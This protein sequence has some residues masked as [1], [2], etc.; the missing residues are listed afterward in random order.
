[1]LLWAQILM[2]G[3]LLLSVLGAWQ[4]SLLSC[5]TA[6]ALGTGLLWY[7][8]RS[9]QRLTALA[10][11]AAIYAA[12]MADP[13]QVGLDPSADPLWNG[14]LIAVL[15]LVSAAWLVLWIGTR[16]DGGL[17]GLTRLEV[18]VVAAGAGVMALR[19]VDQLL[20]SDV[21][22][23]TATLRAIT[24]VVLACLIWWLTGRLYSPTNQPTEALASRVHQL[25]R[26]FLRLSGLALVAMGLL[27][28]YR[29]VALERG[30][31]QGIQAMA[32]GRPRAAV[33]ALEAVR[34]SNHSL[35]FTPLRDRVS[36]GLV[37]AYVATDQLADV[38]RLITDRERGVARHDWQALWEIAELYRL[39]GLHSQAASSYRD[40]IAP[41]R[42]ISAD[43]RE[44]AL[45]GLYQC[46][47]R[48]G[49]PSTLA[50][51]IRRYKHLPGVLQVAPEDLGILADAAM[52]LG[53]YSYAE[54]YLQRRVEL[55]P[56]ANLSHYKLGLVAMAQ[57]RYEAA[58]QHLTH[59]AAARPQFVDARVQLGLCLEKLGRPD[60]SEGSSV[61]RRPA[62]PGPDIITGRSLPN[63][64]RMM[65]FGGLPETVSPGQVL[66]FE[67]HWTLQGHS[68]TTTWQDS[69]RALLRL[70]RYD[71]QEVG[72][73][74][75]ELVTQIGSQSIPLTRD[76]RGA[77]IGAGW[78][79]RHR[80]KIREHPRRSAAGS[81]KRGARR[82]KTDAPSISGAYALECWIVGESRRLAGETRLYVARR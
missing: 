29:V 73:K 5:L 11:A 67:T 77:A 18:V 74:H 27:G 25:R 78:S 81:R 80:L 34:A 56:E 39:A 44:A 46:L 13:G 50:A 35:Q 48:R 36:H 68:A 57:R 61:R 38:R 70:V 49:D 51:A 26:S 41:R 3:L 63:G 42:I 37:A 47:A 6:A 7:R 28:V 55:D 76:G 62:Q 22:P 30:Y 20:N 65:G 71:T 75:R 17:P 8:N 60:P 31:R 1:M 54:E 16:S 52:H 66:S 4:Q 79:E 82:L 15:F 32:D 14:Y 45:E 64:L 53:L 43:Q 12:L 10:G 2:S 9:N 23:S 21:S 24:H 72:G 19:G 40:L 69:A 58:V 33:S 59:A